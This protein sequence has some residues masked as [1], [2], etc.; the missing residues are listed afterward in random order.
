MTFILYSV[1]RPF[2]QDVARVRV[3]F[4][5]VCSWRYHI[6][7]D[8]CSTRVCHPAL[9]L[10]YCCR[11]YASK[12]GAGALH[13]RSFDDEGLPPML[14]DPRISSTHSREV[15]DGGPSNLIDFATIVKQPEKL[16]V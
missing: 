12:R 16:S 6:A 13:G 9:L 1:P 11:L 2:S 5:L 14:Y 4:F 3:C 8:V 15:Y 10:A 7:E